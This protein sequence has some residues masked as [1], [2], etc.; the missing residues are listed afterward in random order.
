MEDADDAVE[1]TDVAAKDTDA[2]IE[3]TDVLW[4]IHQRSC[5][6]VRDAVEESEDAVE[7][8]RML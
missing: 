6:R 2:A 5:G 1:D 3:D 8:P 4:L 7:E